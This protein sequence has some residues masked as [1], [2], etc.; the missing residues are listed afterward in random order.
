MI[1]PGNFHKTF[2]FDET[3]RFSIQM[4]S[5]AEQGGGGVDVASPEA[6][7]PRL[8]VLV[9]SVSKDKVFSANF[10]FAKLRWVGLWCESAGLFD[11]ALAVEA[12]INL[13]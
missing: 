4:L 10:Y 11:A 2:S 1:F 5:A 6:F 7:R 3:A 12:S 9:S 13:S 8:A